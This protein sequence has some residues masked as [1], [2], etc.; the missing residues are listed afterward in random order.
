MAASSELFPTSCS[1]RASTFDATSFQEPPAS[2]V[3][4]P[5]SATIDTPLPET[6]KPG[7][8]G[9][10]G[11]AYEPGA[12]RTN[13]PSAAAAIASRIDWNCAGPSSSTVQTAPWAALAS[14]E[15]HERES[16]AERSMRIV[17]SSWWG[18]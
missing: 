3:T 16:V 7:T 4:G 10:A 15:G 9:I 5:P 17:F 13:S 14:G 18:A 8:R 2:T 11:A 1:P 6:L 12:T